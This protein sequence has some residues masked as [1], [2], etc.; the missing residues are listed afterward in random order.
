MARQGRM[1]ARQQRAIHA[2]RGALCVWL[3]EEKSSN[4]DLTYLTGI[5]EADTA[6]VLE[7]SQRTLYVRRR[8]PTWAM[9]HGP[10][11]GLDRAAEIAEVDAVRP[12]DTLRSDLEAQLRRAERVAWRLGHSHRWDTF[13]ID[14]LATRARH[15]SL[16]NIEDPS[17]WI[18]ALRLRKDAEELAAMRRAGEITAMAMARAA[19]V[20]GEGMSELALAGELESVFRS[21]GAATN[22]FETLVAAGEHAT[23][24]HP[25]P[26]QRPASAG[27]LVLV[28]IGARWA[29]YASDMART[30]PLTRATP[31]QQDVLDLVREAHA[32]VLSAARPG[33]TLA[34][35]HRIA[36]DVIA[37]GLPALGL[38]A[39]VDR[40]FMHRTSHW[41]GLDAHDPRCKGD[42][43][44]ILEEGMTLTIEP[45]LY[46]HADATDAPDALRGVGVRWEDTIAIVASGCEVL[47]TPDASQHDAGHPSSGVD[48]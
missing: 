20:L 42:N 31:A 48:D 18:A 43:D 30:F 46:V 5:A 39:P 23:V 22:A 1:A 44:L 32:A 37:T 36:R 33:A 12:F 16:P 11:L 9:W 14:I 2:A 24:L 29:G 45:G 13:I 25:S 41:I 15:A 47:T 19:E 3:R 7:G 26:T 34:H 4:S 40:W 6:L 21:Q 17:A 8:D 38:S 28:D 27:E 10:R 35:L